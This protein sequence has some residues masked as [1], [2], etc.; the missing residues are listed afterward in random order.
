MLIPGIIPSFDIVQL[1]KPQEIFLS[2]PPFSCFFLKK[3]GGESS[4]QNRPIAWNHD[5]FFTSVLQLWFVKA[6]NS[7]RAL[8]HLGKRV[9]VGGDYV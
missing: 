6:H 4:Q 2:P 8:L 9:A 1:L 5:E 7:G 3:G